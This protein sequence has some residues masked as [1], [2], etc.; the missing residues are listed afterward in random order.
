M[1]E[2]VV[3]AARLRVPP[4][5]DERAPGAAVTVELCGHWEHEAP[6]PIPHHTGV[7]PLGDGLIQVRVVA[8]VAPGEDEA[9]QGRIH[10]ALAR[11]RLDAPGDPAWQLLDDGPAAP[12]DEELE[13]GRRLEQGAAG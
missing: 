3:R 9:I 8:S 7:E 5:G 2:L 11:G 4:G 1:R 13:L 12:T 10:G 6:C